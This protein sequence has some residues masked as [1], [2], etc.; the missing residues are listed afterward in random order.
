[1]PFGI[2]GEGGERGG[3]DGERS[4]GIRRLQKNICLKRSGKK[5]L[6]SQA[7]ERQRRNKEREKEKRPGETFTARFIDL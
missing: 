1:V 5:D 6:L 4:P 7:W 3:D 2:H